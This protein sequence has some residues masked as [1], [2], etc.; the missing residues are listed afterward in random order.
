MSVERLLDSRLEGLPI[1]IGG[2]SARG[3]VSSCSYEARAYGVYPM[4]PMKVARQMCPEGIIIKGS[5]GKYSH[6]SNVVTDIIK[7]EVPSFE[8]R[9]IDEFYIDLTGMDRFFGCFKLATELRHKIIDHTGLP[10]SFGMAANKTVSKVATGEAKPNG[11]IKIE[12]GNEK[13]FLAPLSI[14]KI[15][16]VAD[17]GGGI[18]YFSWNIRD[19]KSVV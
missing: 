14:R 11:R 9:S 13:P 15:P 4:M 10:I 12:V 1:L 6:Y 18:G 8:K 5:S 16:M 7:E 17:P 2:T 3:V 19:R